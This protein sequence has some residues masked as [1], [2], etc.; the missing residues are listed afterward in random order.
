VTSVKLDEY[1]TA[2]PEWIHQIVISRSHCRSVAMTLIGIR[3]FHH[4]NNITGFNDINV[5]KHISKHIWASRM[6]GAWI[7]S[8]VELE[9]K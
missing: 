7:E 6:D 5:I 8:T 3:K 9:T 1:L 4:T 2:I